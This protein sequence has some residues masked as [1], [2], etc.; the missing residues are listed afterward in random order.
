MNKRLVRA[1]CISAATCLGGSLT[2]SAADL[3]VHIANIEQSTGSILIGLYDSAETFLN[4]KGM[5]DSMKLDAHKD[6]VSYTFHDLPEGDYA[7]SVFHDQDGDGK[8][9]K[10]FMGIP[11]EPIGMS[12]DAK[13][14]YGPPQYSDAVFTLPKTGTDLTITLY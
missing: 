3:T 12:R 2:A 4:P 14:S 6:G 13:G 10:N 9:K 8:L 5:R 11:R 7:I 1:L